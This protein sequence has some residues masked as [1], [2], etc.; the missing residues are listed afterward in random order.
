VRAPERVGAAVLWAVDVERIKYSAITGTGCDCAS[1]WE[2]RTRN[3]GGERKEC[4]WTHKRASSLSCQ[5]PRCEPRA[6]D[7]LTPT[8]VFRSILPGCDS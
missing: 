4:A 7:S 1:G 5:A 8:V 6:K 3:V 2:Q